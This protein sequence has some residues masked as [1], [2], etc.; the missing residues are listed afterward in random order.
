MLYRHINAEDP[1]PVR[2]RTLTSWT[3][4]RVKNLAETKLAETE[5]PKGRTRRGAAGEGDELS[6]AMKEK[7]KE[8]MAGFVRD[9]CSKNI[10]VSWGGAPA[11]SVSSAALDSDPRCKTDHTIAHLSGG[12]GQDG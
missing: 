1:S 7:I 3:F 11:V 6:D 12:E 2:F 8:A 4:Q 10:D 9:I 5:Q